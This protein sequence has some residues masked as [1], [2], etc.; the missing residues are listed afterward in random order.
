VLFLV[1]FWW[2]LPIFAQFCGEMQNPALALVEWYAAEGR[3]LP[4]R[5][6]RD[7]YK[8]W[9]SEVIL[10]QTRIDQGL[11]YYER[12]IERFPTVEALA[13]TDTDTLMKYWEGLG[14]YSRARNLHHTA[15]HV[16]EVLGGAFPDDYRALEKLKGIGPYTARAIGSFA[17]DNVVAVLDGNVFRVLSRYLGDFSP[18]DVPA[19]RQHFQKQLDAWLIQATQQTGDAR[20]PSKFNQAMMD[21]GATVCAP[22]KPLCGQCPLA[23]HCRANAEDLQLALPVKAKKLQRKTVYQHFYLVKTAEGQFWIH[24]RPASGLWANLWEIPNLEVGEAD[25][26]RGD[27]AGYLLVGAFKHVFTHLDMMIK[28][29]VG[30]A[31]PGSPVEG[32]KL[33]FKAEIGEY[34]FSRA[35]LKIFEQYLGSISY[36]GED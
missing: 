28:V 12:F 25:W 10:Q 5:H 13:A 23:S 36:F 3:D 30:S 35:V 26:A 22:R 20:T 19:T 18:I 7:P 6:T 29:Y 2:R 8:I 21:L 14:Y 33:I 11:G 15:K 1:V 24:R 27:V 32:S 17:F 4:W 34:A 9:L 31:Y 16:A